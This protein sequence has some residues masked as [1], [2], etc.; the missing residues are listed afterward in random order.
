MNTQNHNPNSINLAAWRSEIDSF[1]DSVSK[2]L[3]D[4]KLAVEGAAYAYEDAATEDFA[5]SARENNEREN[6][7]Q[8]ETSGR[9]FSNTHE[10]NYERADSKQESSAASPE[11]NPFSSY[12]HETFEPIES[13]APKYDSDNSASREPRTTDS[14]RLE[15]LKNQL[16]KRLAASSHNQSKPEEED[17][18]E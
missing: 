7:Q 4:L 9:E 14:L 1:A 5:N 6:N 12:K 2:R 8:S 11:E 10:A 16:A 13:P 15:N 17:V 18:Q 3:D